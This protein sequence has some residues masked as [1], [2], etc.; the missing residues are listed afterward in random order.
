VS[1]PY[2]ETAPDLG[3][4][5]R[6]HRDDSEGCLLVM[7]AVLSIGVAIA[8]VAIGNW[9]GLGLDVLGVAAGLWVLRRPG[10]P[11]AGVIELH[12]NG[13][14]QRVSGTTTVIAFGE[15][16]SI[17]SKITKSLRSGAITE[18]HRVESRDGLHIDFGTSW[19]LQRDLLAAIEER[20]VPRLRTAALRAFD[21]GQPVTFGP[22]TLSEEGIRCEGQPILP[23][24]D[25]V[26]V[27]VEGGMIE[28]W[29]A[30]VWEKKGR[31]YAARGASLVPNA[32][33]FVEMCQLAIEREAPT[34][35]E[36]APPSSSA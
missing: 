16:R 2:R 30:D 17:T 26:R 3:P 13:L 23:W 11:G 22:F 34:G 10:R 12:E 8:M 5:L 9:W 32:R 20:T 7:F 1:A 19:R 15:V 33:I 21:E 18:R 29:K 28:V 4:L 35:D 25:A 36:G 31:P 14:L 27:T 24:T 6:V